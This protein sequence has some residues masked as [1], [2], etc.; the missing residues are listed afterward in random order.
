MKDPAVAAKNA[1]ERALL[2]PQSNVRSLDLRCLAQYLVNATAGR[3]CLAHTMYFQNT[4]PVAPPAETLLHCNALS[5]KLLADMQLFCTPSWTVCQS[6]VLKPGLDLWATPMLC[7]SVL[8]PS[9]CLRG[10]TLCI[11]WSM[12]AQCGAGGA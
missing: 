8:S 9:G 5:V 2:N 12:T 7:V 3:A 10:T 4:S 1:R 6:V 11:W